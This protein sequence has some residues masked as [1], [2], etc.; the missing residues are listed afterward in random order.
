MRT[1]TA[2]N[3]YPIST[4]C[5][6]SHFPIKYHFSM[7]TLTAKMTISYRPSV[8]P[9]PINLSIPFSNGLQNRKR[10]YPCEY[11]M[12]TVSSLIK[13]SSA[14]T[15]VVAIGPVNS[16]IPELRSWNHEHPI[17]RPSSYKSCVPESAQGG[18]GFPES[19]KLG[20]P[21]AF[22]GGTPRGAEKLSEVSSTRPRRRKKRKKQRKR[23]KK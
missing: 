21:S 7:K 11:L 20:A 2:K 23:K 19:R 13:P 9:S 22:A 10:Y 18:R 6:T 1:L 5:K 8:R 14:N 16:K 12:L 3:V 4:L 17:S 15:T